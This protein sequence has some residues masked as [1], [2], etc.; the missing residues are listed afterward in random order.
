MGACAARNESLPQ[1]AENVDPERFMGMWYEIARLP[2]PPERDCAAF[3]TRYERVNDE[4]FGIVNYC[5]HKSA[6]GPMRK[7]RADARQ[8]EHFTRFDSADPRVRD[9]RA[10][11]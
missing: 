6:S 8:P 2:F 1:T 7:T 4:E 10:L 5:W 11:R 3:A 9:G